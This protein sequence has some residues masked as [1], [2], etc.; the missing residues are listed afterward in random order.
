M[1][2]LELKNKLGLFLITSHFLI[3]VIIIVLYF[4]N[5]FLFEEMTTSVALIS[6]VFAVYTTAI[7]K[8][9]IANQ[10]LTRRKSRKLTS[11]FITISFAIPS[12]FV[13]AVIAITLLKAFN[14]GFS[15]YEQYKQL[16]AILEAVFAIYIGY[17]ISSLFGEISTETVTT[18]PAKG[19]GAKSS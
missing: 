17:V 9:F 16:F 1:T 3:V 7:V 13:I 19:D 12:I 5:G 18:T 15:S 14:I 11:S 8:F 10:T 6:P 4:F 2:E